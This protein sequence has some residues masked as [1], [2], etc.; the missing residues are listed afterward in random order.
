MNA[1]GYRRAALTIAIEA[2][3]AEI[4][5]VGRRRAALEKQVEVLKTTSAQRMTVKATPSSRRRLPLVG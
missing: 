2:A 3:E 1:R 5:D 4:A